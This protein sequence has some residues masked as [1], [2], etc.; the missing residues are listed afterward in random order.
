MQKKNPQIALTVVLNATIYTG[1]FDGIRNDHP[2]QRWFGHT[3][4]DVRQ[5]MLNTEETKDKVHDCGEGGRA[6]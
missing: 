5:M 2:L 1:I 6:D 3:E 4:R